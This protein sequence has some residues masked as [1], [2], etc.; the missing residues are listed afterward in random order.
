MKWQTMILCWALALPAAAHA[1]ADAVQGG[2][3]EAAYAEL[4]PGAVLD[5]LDPEAPS[6]RRAVALAAYERLSGLAQCPEFGYT[7]GQ[8]Y[9]HG[10]YLPGNLVAQDID[11]ARALIR[12]MAEDG[13][14][15]AF[16]DL[17]EMEMRHA[18]T[19]DAMKWTQVYLHF[20]RTVQAD[21]VDD[22]AT[23]RFHRTAYNSHLLARTEV[24]WRKFTRPRLPRRL[25]NED[26]NAYLDEH[27]ERVS[28]LM[29][30]RRAGARGRASAHD[31]GPVDPVATPDT[32]HL[33]AIEGVGSAS[34]SWIVEVLPTGAVGR[35]V[36]ENLVP[37]AQAAAALG[38][39]LKD[40]RFAAFQGER[41]ATVRVSLM[42]GSTGS[43][44]LS[45][46]RR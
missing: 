41:P 40:Y 18:N 2:V 43:R 32:C 7:L 28:R 21:F 33:N 9:R 23:E 15:P 11:R 10:P 17:A 46:R 5:L 4:P 36:L 24:L 8:L 45:P 14:L 20:V 37:N 3:C 35:V 1:A 30:E 25:V 16:A 26:L 31:G 44:G 39:C 27:G 12:P 38:R 22:P 29:R 34:A 19:R 13:Y 6:E 42:M